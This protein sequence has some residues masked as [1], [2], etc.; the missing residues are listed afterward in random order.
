MPLIVSL[1]VPEEY[2]LPTL[3][4][5]A[6][7][8]T[9]SLALTLGAEAYETLQGT[10]IK[11]IRSETHADAIRS[12]KT[13]M[14]AEVATERAQAEE[15]MRRIRQ[16]KR[17]VEEA[18]LATQARVEALEQSHSSI[19]SSSKAE[20][21]ESFEEV[22]RAKD[23]QI[24]QLQAIT[25]RFDTLQTSLTKSFSSSK[26]KG[27][28]GEA[29]TESMLK[30]AFDCDIQPVSKDANTSDI[31]MIRGPEQEYFWEVKNYTRMV[32]ADE[33][34][35][36][37]RDMRLHP[38]IRGG[39]L[40]SLRTGITGKARG[41]DIDI[42]FLQDGRFI[43]YLSNLLARDD[44]VFYLQT[45]RPFFQAVEVYSRPP[46]EET[47]TVR[48]LEIKAALIANLLRSHT[49]TVAKHRNSIVSHKKRTDGM[50][51]EFQAHVMEAESQIQSL[52]RV[53]LGSDQD[54]D[55]VMKETETALPSSIFKKE[56]LSEYDGRTKAFVGWLLEVTEPGSQ[57]EIKEVIERGKDGGYGEKFI[58]DL[59]E[60]VF[61]QM[62]WVKGA[63]YITGLQWKGL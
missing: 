21:K 32:T 6:D 48:N 33:I 42:E 43:L 45:L 38:H 22:L 29:F 19:R 28:Y 57:L 7:P 53:A 58:R 44:I 41:G 59:R 37:R 39:C 50:F 56:R 5:N 25:G 11:T 35:K 15:Q 46:Q 12:F 18:L 30:K 31:R 36:F 52:L 20:A 63:R 17:R 27:A 10:A 47:E 8:N 55:A 24:T 14:D 54:S 23:E 60:E 13:E 62:A 2:V 1:T 51:A 16:E 26:E 4:K 49:T 61:Q 34:E 3:Y 40:V 9:V